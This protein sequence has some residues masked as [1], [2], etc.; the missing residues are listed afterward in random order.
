M[1]TENRVF[2]FTKEKGQFPSSLFSASLALIVGMVLLLHKINR[3]R[4]GEQ[5]PP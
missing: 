1:G 4:E 2:H 5:M 3:I